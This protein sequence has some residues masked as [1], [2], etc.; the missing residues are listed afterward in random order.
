MPPPGQVPEFDA[1]FGF[2]RSPGKDPTEPP[3]PKFYPPSSRPLFVLQTGRAVNW[4]SSNRKEVQW[5]GLAQGRSGGGGQQQ[6]QQQ[7]RQPTPEP[8]RHHHTLPQ[9]GRIPP[10]HKH[11]KKTR[12]PENNRNPKDN[13]NPKDNQDAYHHRYIQTY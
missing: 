11:P 4:K 1:P 8:P 12:N 5:Y 3:K 10:P 13:H 9:P 7:Q 6:Q 2:Y